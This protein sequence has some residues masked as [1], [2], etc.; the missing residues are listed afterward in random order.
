MSS[1][2]SRRQR[3]HEL[4]L[5]LVAREDELPL[6]EA[7]RPR[8]AGLNVSASGEIPWIV[9]RIQQGIKGHGGADQGLVTLKRA[10]V[11]IQ[12]Q[13]RGTATLQIG[14]IGLQQ[15]QLILPGNQ[16]QQQLMQTLA[17]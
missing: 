9:L 12:P 10:A 2:V 15:R 16:S 1:A 7:D 13:P 17:S 14:A 5:A 11:L 4:L 6:L 8:L 3:L